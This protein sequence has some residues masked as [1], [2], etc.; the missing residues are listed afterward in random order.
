MRTHIGPMG[1]AETWDGLRDEFAGLQDDLSEL[2]DRTPRTVHWPTDEGRD[3]GL[4]AASA[5][6]PAAA[7]S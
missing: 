1:G 5:L 2:L 6:A 3:D 7:Y 4:H